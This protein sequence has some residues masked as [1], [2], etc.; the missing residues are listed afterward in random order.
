MSAY[1]TT[2]GLTFYE[3]GERGHRCVAARADRQQGPS[4]AIAAIL[5]SL[6]TCRCQMADRTHMPLERAES[7]SGG[8]CGRIVSSDNPLAVCPP[9]AASVHLHYGA[10]Q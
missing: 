3:R 1:C 9:C 7:P 4:A 8:P 2:C 5:A 10:G 6:P